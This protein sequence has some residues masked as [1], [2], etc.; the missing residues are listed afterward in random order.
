LLKNSFNLS[1]AAVSNDLISITGI[2][3]LDGQIKGYV[4]FSDT[5]NPKFALTVDITKDFSAQA[6]K[7]D[8]L[9]YF[10]IDKLPSALITL[11]GMD[12]DKLKPVFDNWISY[13][14]TP[15]ETEARKTLDEMEKPKSTVDESVIKVYEKMLNEEILPFVKVVNDNLDGVSVFKMDFSPTAEMID[16]IALKTQTEYNKT[17]ENNGYKIPEL[18]AG[19]PKVSDVFKDVK[20]NLWI[21]RNDYYLRKATLTFTADPTNP[22]VSSGLENDLPMPV[23]LKSQITVSFALTM[24][25]FGKDVPIELPAN[26]LT[27]DEIF[28]Q[29]MGDSG[30]LMAINPAEQ[31]ARARNSQRRS[32]IR[33][34]LSAV[35]LYSADKMGVYPP[36]IS[37][38][39]KN[40]SK[41]GAD[42]CSVLLPEYISTLPSD[43]SL[44]QQR[45][46]DKACSGNYETGYAIVKSVDG[47]ITISAPTAELG[48]EI[49][50]TR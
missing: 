48:D 23:S 42:I 13:D 20:F 4:D 11:A 21:G 37:T 12:Q 9:V 18:K 38:T 17:V 19:Q 33:A 6:R 34:I 1:A 16:R 50:I 32:D 31:L 24:S 28:E 30:L 36:G 49:S 40:I 7:N 8:R 29:I 5:K 45:I 46:T 15:L 39:V 44:K 35:E 43:P 14:T 22:G 41:T 47:E 25:D 3:N 26:S 27:P 10:K 2:S